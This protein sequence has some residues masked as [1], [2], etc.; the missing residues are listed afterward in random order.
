M[1]IAPSSPPSFLIYERVDLKGSQQRRTRQQQRE[2][3]EEE[4][5]RRQNTFSSHRQSS[6]LSFLI[7]DIFPLHLH[8]SIHANDDSPSLLMVGD[9]GWF[10]SLEEEENRERQDRE[11]RGES[12]TVDTPETL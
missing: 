7:Q 9:G 1:T 2:G 3:Q 10:L 12:E 11:E 8:P 5:W 6:P 4:T